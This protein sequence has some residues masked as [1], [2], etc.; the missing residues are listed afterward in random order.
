SGVDGF[1]GD[2]GQAVDAKLST[3]VGLATDATGD[4]YIADAGNNRIRKVNLTTGVITTVAGSGFGFSG[5]GG[6]AVNAQMYFPTAVAL[7]KGGNLFIADTGNNR[8]RKVSPAGVISTVAG[9]GTAGSSGDGGPAISAQ[10]NAPGGLTFDSAGNLYFADQLNH[11]V[12]RITPDALINK[13]AGVGQASNSLDGFEAEITSLNSPAGVAVD[14][15]GNLFIADTGNHRVLVVAAYRGLANASAASFVASVTSSE[16]IIAAFGTRLATRTEPAT[17][18]PLPVSL[19][20][21]S[22]KV[23]DSLGNER[24]AALFFV[25]SAQ[26]NYQI[27]P[28]M[29]FGNATVT[30]TSGDGTIS[31]GPITNTPVAPGLFTATADGQGVA[32]AVALRIKNDGSQIYEPVAFFDQSQNKFVARPIDLGPDLGSASDQVFLI[33]FG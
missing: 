32:A 3:P 1:D 17:S 30:I 16:M 33:L 26:V 9:V 6:A 28:G 22:V 4:L 15:I 20:G 12:R 10:L 23:R 2:G 27:P 18:L 19:A 11:S 21:T 5:D 24:T 13:I 8:I 25:S 29:A 7:D 31:S 14:G